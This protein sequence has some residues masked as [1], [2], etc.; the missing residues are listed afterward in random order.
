MLK[1][2]WFWKVPSP[3]PSSVETNSVASFGDGQ[4]ELPI[5]IE[6]RQGD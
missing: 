5:A 2:R 6:V 3:L 4:V 1:S